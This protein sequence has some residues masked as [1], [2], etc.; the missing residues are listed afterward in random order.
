M[1]LSYN[2]TKNEG[3]RLECAVLSFYNPLL[4]QQSVQSYEFPTTFITTFPLA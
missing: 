1:G 2:F 3:L 4:P